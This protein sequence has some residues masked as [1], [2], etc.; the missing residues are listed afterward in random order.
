MAAQ[1]DDSDAESD[2][3]ALSSLSA[4]DARWSPI[5]E[6]A[7]PPLVPSEAVAPTTRLQAV[8][9]VEQEEECLGHDQRARAGPSTRRSTRSSLPVS[10]DAKIGEVDSG[11]EPSRRASEVVGLDS[12]IAKPQADG[13]AK[14]AKEDQKRSKSKKRLAPRDDD[15]YEGRYD[16]ELAR[17]SSMRNRKSRGRRQADSASQITPTPSALSLDESRARTDVERPRT[18]RPRPSEADMLLSSAPEA[19][20]DLAGLTRRTAKLLE[21]YATSSARPAVALSV[22][23]NKSIDSASGIRPSSK[24]ERRKERVRE[25]KRAKPSR[26]QAELSRDFFACS[27]DLL[28]D[29]DAKPSTRSSKRLRSSIALSTSAPLSPVASTSTAQPHADELESIESRALGM[30]KSDSREDSTEEERKDGEGSSRP[31]REVAELSRDIWASPSESLVSEE[32]PTTRASKR[33]R[34]AERTAAD[35]TDEDGGLPL[36]EPPAAPLPPAETLAESTSADTMSA[37]GTASK[38]ARR[39]ERKTKEERKKA[40]K[41]SGGA[42]REVADLRRDFF[43]VSDV[44]ALAEESGRS[45]RKSKRRCESSM[46]VSPPDP[47]PTPA[48][49]ATS[50]V[51][52]V[53]DVDHTGSTTDAMSPEPSTSLLKRSSRQRRLPARYDDDPDR[54]TIVRNAEIFEEQELRARMRKASA[55]KATSSTMWTG[56][57]SQPGETSRQLAQPPSRPT[58]PSLAETGLL[59]LPIKTPR[60]EQHSPAFSAPSPL[61]TMTPLA[62]PAA[63]VSAPT[64][65]VKKTKKARRAVPIVPTDPST[66]L[67]QPA[68]T[69]APVE[70]ASDSVSEAPPA[71]PAPNKAPKQ[72]QA[73]KTRIR[74]PAL[75]SRASWVEPE[76]NLTLTTD[77]RPP[78]WCEGRQELCETLNYFKAYQGGH[79][80]SQERCLGYLLDGFGSANDVCTN[81]GKIVISHGGGC[82]EVVP[83]TSAPSTLKATSSST[84]KTS[85]ASYIYRLKSSQ[86]RDNLRLRALFN[87]LETQTPVVLLAGAG[88]T[89]FPKLSSLGS[90]INEDGE[91]VDKAR[92]AVLGHYLVTDIW[93]E[94]EP[95]EDDGAS[96]GKDKPGHFVRFKVRF[97]WVPSQGKPW[98]EDHIGV[99]SISKEATPEPSSPASDAAS[100]DS[101]FVDITEATAEQASV[102]EGCVTCEACHQTHRRVYQENVSCYNEACSNFFLVDG[103]M[104]HPSSLTYQP[105]ILAPSDLPQ[106][107]LVPQ[108]LFPRTLQSLAGEVAA[109]DYSAEAWRGFG[110]TACGRL[111]SRADWI[112][113]KCAGCGAEGN[114]VGKAFTI[115]DLRAEERLAAIKA[116]KIPPSDYK[117]VQ[118]VFVEPSMR[119]RPILHIPGWQGYTVEMLP[120]VTSEDAEDSTASCSSVGRALAHHLWPV[121]DEEA[122]MADN[123]FEG[124]QGAE[125]GEFFRRNKLSRH[126]AVGGL[127]CQQFTF[128]AGEHYRN[129]ITATTYPFPPTALPS[130]SVETPVPDDETTYAPEC[131]REA[132][133]HLKTVVQL[134]VGPNELADF[135]EILSVAYMSGGKMNYHDDGERGLGP[136]VASVSLGSDALMTF[137]AKGK[138]KTR[139][140]GGGAGQTGKKAK[141]ATSTGDEP[142]ETEEGEGRKADKTKRIV[143]KMRL[144]HGDVM[145]MEG[146]EMQRL[147]EHKVEP[148]GLRYAATARF[149]GPDH[150]NPAPKS[151]PQPVSTGARFAYQDAALTTAT[152]APSNIGASTSKAAY[153]IPLESK[154]PAGVAGWQAYV[155]QEDAQFFPSTVPTT[156]HT[157]RSSTRPATR[158]RPTFIQ[159]SPVPPDEWASPKIPR[160]ALP[161]LPTVPSFPQ[162]LPQSGAPPHAILP[163]RPPGPL[164]SPNP[165]ATHIPIRM[166]QPTPPPA[167]APTFGA[168]QPAMQ[169]P[170]LVH[171]ALERRQAGLLAQNHTAIM[172][173]GM[174]GHVAPTFVPMGAF[175]FP[176]MP[177]PQA[178]PRPF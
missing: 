125:A 124:Y 45:T 135:N 41:G 159:P 16:P 114:A 44:D 66:S 23:T 154:K 30:P 126:H 119:V 68:T 178:M 112:K 78:I 133:N 69:A 25:E 90:S 87:C 104:H 74:H 139:A 103:E 110:C 106:D 101:G 20:V 28:S 123:L 156:T 158:R 171:S 65:P 33:L 96:K 132:R 43:S 95:I 38:Q 2:C 160:S 58:L 141:G 146:E 172:A 97:E 94:G 102:D 37:D 99:E 83:V 149:V 54:F 136:Y 72:S 140:F 71:V 128:N 116:G 164:P 91:E 176:Q 42:A 48:A 60:K 167:P 153:A 70:T 76:K 165:L 15:E 152:P 7:P 174:P 166:S 85:N 53:V 121:D 51:D 177:M 138:K 162:P 55:A 64:A 131:T 52:M 73:T 109:A 122:E 18:K 40:K 113:L 6:P 89:F 67:S 75:D 155:Q 50:S 84:I 32:K 144:R 161:P 34:L 175:V 57:P 93:P 118:P 100:L 80:D 137:R 4:L 107:T 157:P 59:T 79:Y 143:C 145:V 31:R 46:V 170:S 13:P 21:V 127:L 47:A 8:M 3:S 77:G 105:S 130:S 24:K 9:D 163:P 26:E 86:T 92:Y 142:E 120:S 147:F 35:S 108:S 56:G 17:R 12:G 82:G 117:P 36:G 129:A 134:L 1:G 14:L 63:S 169:P 10:P 39:K 11:S 27:S 22:D 173:H 150:L 88:W 148:E 49:P 98:F 61:T 115:Q 62:R 19:T 151:R 5:E 29:D 111:S 81:K 168:P